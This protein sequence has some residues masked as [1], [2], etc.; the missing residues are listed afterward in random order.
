MSLYMSICIIKTHVTLSYHITVHMQCTL[1][2]KNTVAVSVVDVYQMT[3]TYVCNM[4]AIY[5]SLDCYWY[6]MLF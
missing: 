2:K 4:L 1:T 6:E 5:M 3:V